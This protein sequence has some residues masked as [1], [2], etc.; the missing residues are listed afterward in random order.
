MIEKASGGILFLDEIGDL[1]LVSQVKLL[2]LLQEGEYYPV[3]SDT[4]K[5]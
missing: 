5:E 3:G 4:P 1:S 2:R